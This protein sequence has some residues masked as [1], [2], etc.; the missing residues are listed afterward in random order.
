[1]KKTFALLLVLAMLMGVVGAFAEGEALSLDQ[2]A[3][4][5][6]SFSSGA[7]G[8]STEMRIANDGS[9]SGEY[10]D[11]EM[12]E[13]GDDY[14]N[15]SLYVS[16][17]TGTLSIGEQV[18]EHAW[19]VQ[20]DSLTL[21]DEPGQENIDDGIRFVTTEPYGISEGDIMTLYLPGT[22]VDALTEDMKMWSHVILEDP[23]PTEL[24]NW[25]L[26]S[27]KNQSGFVGYDFSEE[28]ETANPWVDMTEEE[29]WQTA[30]VTLNLPEGAQ[31]TAFRWLAEESLAEMD[32][33][34]DGDEYCARVKPAALEAGQVENISDMYFA[35]ENE[36]K[37]TVGHC[38]GTLGQAQTGSQDFV[39]LCLWYDLV[40]GLM[41]SLSVS[42]TDLDG[43]DLV[44]VA[45]MVYVPMQGDA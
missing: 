37:V 38:E 8:W 42:T 7:G 17:F 19:K 1:M 35:W 11:S 33:T 13:V 23:M 45:E 28:A 3:G 20:I 18:D 22:P 12:G 30:G 15:G 40:P 41:Y 34:L 39:E 6:W 16:G 5:E 24:N 32:F 25:F 31:A 9:F 29:L 36:E 44:A 10:H 27:E 21:K 2:L 43:L 26:Y 14:P 4:L